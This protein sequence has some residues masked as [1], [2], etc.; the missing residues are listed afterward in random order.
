MI[1]VFWRGSCNFDEAKIAFPY[2]K[3]I[4]DGPEE[5][6]ERCSGN[7]INISQR[8]GIDREHALDCIVLM[9]Y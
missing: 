2:C 9:K 6:V 1:F 5:F 4:C 3:S 8:H 7:G